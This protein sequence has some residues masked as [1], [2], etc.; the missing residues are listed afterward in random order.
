MQQQRRCQQQFAR[1]RRRRSAAAVLLAVALVILGVPAPITASPSGYWVSAS[2]P[3]AG[4][5]RST[6]SL[7]VNPSGTKVYVPHILYMNPGNVTVQDA[8]TGAVVSTIRGGMGTGGVVLNADGSRLYVS[9]SGNTQNPRNQGTGPGVIQVVDTRTNTVTTQIETDRGGA[10][11]AL[12]PDGGM[13]FGI[14]YE[15]RNVTFV[16]TASNAIVAKVPIPGRPAGNV[17]VSPDGS[18]LYVGDTYSGGIHMVSVAERR[19]VKSIETGCTASSD[20]ALNPSGTRLYI[21]ACVF[22]GT[23]GIV[24][25]ATMASRTVPFAGQPTAIAFSPDGNAAYVVDGSETGRVFV[26]DSATE[27]VIATFPVGQSPRGIVISRDGSALFVV[28]GGS[29]VSRIDLQANGRQVFTDVPAG[30]AFFHEITWLG[31]S[32]ISTG[33]P[34]GSFRPLAPV[35][36][37]QMAAFLFRK[38]GSPAWFIPPAASPFRDLAPGDAFYREITWLA[39][40]RITTGYDD[41]TF[42]PGTPVSR[43]AMAAFLYRYATTLAGAPAYPAPATA[44]FSDVRPGDAFHREVS[45]A[46]AAGIT[47]G[48]SDG[49]FRP[50]A[51][52]LREATAAFLYRLTTPD[53]PMP[54]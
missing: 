26:L 28:H 36:R 48:Y 6:S 29:G 15:G 42:R 38:A 40:Q 14:M 9:N 47:K 7:A 39:S 51:P 20:L 37:D 45:W 54:R 11:L 31:N 44:P 4:Q 24:D 49:T 19:V 46:A 17:A 3:A 30:A 22:P 33:Y 13:L 2:F 34:D 1:P 5:S 43:E 21:M 41:G 25:T 32:G 18:M 27:T 53:R 50:G 8:A 52:V 12:S 35:R 16:D 10:R 23:V